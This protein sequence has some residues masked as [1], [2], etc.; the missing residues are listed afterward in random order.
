M[1]RQ[2]QG[3]AK[4]VPCRA[5]VKR[6]FHMLKKGKEK[7]KELTDE[8]LSVVRGGLLHAS[9]KERHRRKA[10]EARKNPDRRFY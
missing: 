3:T 4:S 6:G 7:I 1:N 8:L 10:E 9:P 2:L 5:I